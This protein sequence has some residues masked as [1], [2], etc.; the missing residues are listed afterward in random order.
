M[1]QMRLNITADLVALKGSV[2]YRRNACYILVKQCLTIL[3]PSNEKDPCCG[4]IRFQHLLQLGSNVT[5]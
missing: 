3:N 4:P 5:Y 1:L 2:A